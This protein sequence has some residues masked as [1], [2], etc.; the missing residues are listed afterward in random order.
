MG[1]LESIEERLV[2]VESLL[3][4]LLLAK[5]KAEEDEELLTALEAAKILKVS[6]GTIEK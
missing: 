1:V 2:R 6:K 3:N 4:E 5:K